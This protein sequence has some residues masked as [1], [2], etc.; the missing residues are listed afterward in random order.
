LKY[1]ILLTKKTR[2]PSSPSI[3]EDKK[4]NFI[5]SSEKLSNMHPK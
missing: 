3:C 5:Y 2:D 4:V 1:T